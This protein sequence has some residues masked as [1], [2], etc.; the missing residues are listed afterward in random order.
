M[1]KTAFATAILAVLSSGAR[2]SG[3]NGVSTVSDKDRCTVLVADYSA[4]APEGKG[5]SPARQDSGTTPIRS[6]L[7]EI[8]PAVVLK[9]LVQVPT[10][11]LPMSAMPTRPLTKREAIPVLPT[12]LRQ[13]PPRQEQR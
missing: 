7:I 2:A 5:S 8:H 12:H 6:H 10:S 1:R 13:R 11:S 3:F 9:P 4:Q